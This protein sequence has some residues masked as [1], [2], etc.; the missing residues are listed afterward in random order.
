V[1]VKPCLS[2]LFPPENLTHLKDQIVFLFKRRELFF[3]T[4]SFLKVELV[5]IQHFKIVF[6]V[7]KP[8]GFSGAT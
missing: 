8:E 6:T 5:F 3:W 4:D 1:G 7:F 2:V